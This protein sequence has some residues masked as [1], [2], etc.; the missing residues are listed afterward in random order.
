[1]VRYGK[2]WSA[3]GVK[4]CVGRQQVALAV[5]GAEVVGGSNSQVPSGTG[6]GRVGKIMFR[7]RVRNSS[8]RVA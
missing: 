8:S 6:T 3:V 1:M 7:K 5:G 4:E 2:D